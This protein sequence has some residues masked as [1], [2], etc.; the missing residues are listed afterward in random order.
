M[1]KEERQSIWSFIIFLN[2]IN[3]SGEVNVEFSTIWCRNRQMTQKLTEGQEELDG[4]GYELANAKV[5]NQAL[6]EKFIS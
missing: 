1:L 2:D 3:I 6:L 5:E 4:V